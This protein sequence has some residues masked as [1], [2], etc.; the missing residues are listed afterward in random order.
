[1]IAEHGISFA[2]EQS[3]IGAEVKVPIAGIANASRGLNSE[4]RVPFNSE[5]ER[6]A[7][8][9]HRALGE[10]RGWIAEHSE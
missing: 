1:M 8:F 7:G 2:G 3:A 10:V 4:K 6:T 5:I 9:L